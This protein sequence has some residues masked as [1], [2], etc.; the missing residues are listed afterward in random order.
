MPS[1]RWLFAVGVA[2]LALTP[3]R[4]EIVKGVMSITGAEMS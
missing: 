1:H 4:A 2:L 3:G